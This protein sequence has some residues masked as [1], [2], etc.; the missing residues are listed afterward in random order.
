M[1]SDK[2]LHDTHIGYYT[3]DRRFAYSEFANEQ[4]IQSLCL[5][6]P[7][8]QRV[9]TFDLS[10]GYINATNLI[11]DFSDSP[12]KNISAW[13]RNVK[14]K[15]I[16]SFIET[17]CE[18]KYYNGD[19]TYPLDSAVWKNGKI[20]A[21]YYISK[22][23]NDSDYFG[24]YIHCDLLSSLI[25]YVNNKISQRISLLI[26]NILLKEGINSNLTLDGVIHNSRED[27]EKMLVE[28]NNT[29]REL[30]QSNKEY[31]SKLDNFRFDA[32]KMQ[33]TIDQQS[34]KIKM[35]MLYANPKKRKILDFQCVLI[36]RKYTKRYSESDLMNS[37]LMIII[38]NQFDLSENVELLT[39]R[40]DTMSTEISYSS[41]VYDKLIQ[42]K[43]CSMSKIKEFANEFGLMY[44]I[45]IKQNR[46]YLH[47]VSIDV[48]T[49]TL[50]EYLSEFIVF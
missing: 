28:K 33:R 6:N 21:K 50:R 31:I 12:S 4:E 18:S 46:Y 35:H 24:T 19:R 36:V 34:D 1:I 7:E 38:C 3:E 49:S 29:I 42:L 10:T 16:I 17:E 8:R 27:L 43:E 39:K 5:L 40:K 25:S 26:F 14:T 22:N 2:L 9:I 11:Q 32:L 20:H 44:D 45:H 48:F 23:R 41:V 37:K 47:N 13:L 30:E 15:E